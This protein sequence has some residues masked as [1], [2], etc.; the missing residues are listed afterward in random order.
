MRSAL[1]DCPASEEA[2][3]IPYV[4]DSDD[5]LRMGDFAFTVESRNAKFTEK[6][7]IELKGRIELAI[8]GYQFQTGF[9][10]GT[11][12]VEEIEDYDFD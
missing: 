12:S 3:N 8:L 1:E 7:V 11:A 10:N 4:W 9:T 2:S 5:F 6:Q